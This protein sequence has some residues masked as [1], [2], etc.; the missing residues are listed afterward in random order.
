MVVNDE[1]VKKIEELVFEN[2]WFTTS[3]LS[4]NVLIPHT[5]LYKVV[6][7]KLGYRKF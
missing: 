1:L 3:Q 2:L 6:I 4:K 7:E 5:V